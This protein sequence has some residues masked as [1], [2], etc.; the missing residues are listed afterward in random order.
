MACPVSGVH[1]EGYN[2]KGWVSDFKQK[3]MI[4]YRSDVPSHAIYRLP[5][6]H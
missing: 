4:P 6:K 3:N 1:I 2:G 5:D